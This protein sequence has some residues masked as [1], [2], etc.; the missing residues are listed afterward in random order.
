MYKLTLTYEERKAINW[1]SYRYFHGDDLYKLLIRCDNYIS[2]YRTSNAW[3]SLDDITFIIPE[4]VAWQIRANFEAENC[5]F[6]C[7]SSELSNK[8]LKFCFNIV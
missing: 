8:L 1:I 6:A 5:E 4:N 3:D 2:D 7:F